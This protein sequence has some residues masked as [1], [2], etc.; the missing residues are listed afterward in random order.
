MLFTFGD[1]LA[2]TNTRDI[3]IIYS[4]DDHILI[5]KMEINHLY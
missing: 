5:I 2:W 1:I 3:I 4:V